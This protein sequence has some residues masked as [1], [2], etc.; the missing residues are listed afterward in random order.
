MGIASRLAAVFGLLGPLLLVA[1]FVAPF[2]LSWPV[3]GGTPAQLTAYALNHQTTFYAGAWLQ[4]TGTLLCV[5]FFVG[6]VRLA[7]LESSLAGM[8]V[9]VGSACLLAVVVIESALMVAVPIAASK[10]DAATVST[11]FTLVNGVFVRVF[12][13]APSS[14]TYIALGLVL[15]SSDVI[16]RWF[17]YAAMGIG[18]A[19]EV[20]GA[21]AIFIGAFATAL[22]VLA[23]GQAIWVISAAIAVWSGANVAIRE[24]TRSLLPKMGQSARM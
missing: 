9:L 16:H 18:L 3:A 23:G 8:L 6:L 1:Y 24:S 17:G 2:L 14:A 20:A 13:L 4:T 11:T 5:V 10:S 21:G 22:T 19:F 15:L 7:R 12:P